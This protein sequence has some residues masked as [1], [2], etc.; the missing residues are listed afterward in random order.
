MKKWLIRDWKGHVSPSLL[1][2]ITPL[3]AFFPSNL[4]FMKTSKDFSD[5]HLWYSVI[6]RPPSSNFTCV[7]RVSC[8][9]S[10]LL[11]TMLTSIMFY[12]IPA[13]PSEQTM[14]LGT[15]H[16]HNTAI[17]LKK[18]T[19][20][21][22]IDCR[23]YFLICTICTRL[24]C[25][26]RAVLSFLWPCEIA[27]S[28]ENVVLSCLKKKILYDYQLHKKSKNLFHLFLF[29]SVFPG[30]FEFTWQ[31]FMIGV[32]SSLIMFPVNILIVT[33]FRNTRPWETSCCMQK[34]DKTDVLEQT[35]SSQTAVTNETV[36]LATVVKVGA[37]FCS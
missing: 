22:L 2:T 10:L 34:T 18:M 16:L 14:D 6:N 27:W 11:C 12:G 4:F 8:C 13:D 23:L 24:F 21:C 28:C 25:A 17:C 20:Q 33:I 30:H 15:T 19:H 32:Q 37:S 9:F 1:L 26:L 7:Q 3:L 36:T 29:F 35:S 31:Q 5:G